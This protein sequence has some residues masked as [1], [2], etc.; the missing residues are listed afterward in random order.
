M[1]VGALFAPTQSAN[2][3]W[4]KSGVKVMLDP[5]H[6]GSDPGAVYNGGG[7]QNQREAFLALWC[8]QK[9]DSWLTAQ[10]CPHKLTRTTD[11]DVSLSARR[12]ASISYDPWVFCSVHLNAATASATGTETWYYWSGRS[13]TLAKKVQNRL[14]SFLG[15]ANRGVKQNGWTVITGASYI[16]AVLTE[17]L[18]I[19][20]AT[21]WGMLKGANENSA[22]FKGWVNGHLCGFYDFMNSESA[23][24]SPDPTTA[25]WAMTT[26]APVPDPTVTVTPSTVDFSCYVGEHPETELKVTGKNLTGNITIACSS[27]RYELVGTG[28]VKADNGTT[29]VTISKGSGTVNATYKVRLALSDA[30]GS[31]EANWMK[32]TVKSSGVTDI[33]IP[34]KCTISNPPLNSFDEKWVLSEKKN[35][36]DSKGYDASQIRNF[37]YNDG[38]LYGVYQH[39]DIIVINA[40]TGEKLG[41]LKRGN[42][43]SGGILDLCDVKVTDDGK[44]VACN[45]AKDDNLRLYTWDNDNAN[46][47]LLKEIAPADFQGASRLG[48]C[49]EVKGIGR[50]HV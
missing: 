44:I 28:V 22:G 15:R 1:L 24:L 8:C 43:V 20:N 11:K 37:C 6:G 49:M 25:G 10:D 23:G 18:F 29:S 36:H 12:S 4:N 42:V 27:S 5:G 39:K 48:D 17:G 34:L 26:V 2:A 16:P 38:K 9:M 3:T 31:W 40:Q 50:A 21:D 46:P 35:N 30:A 14:V 45:L 32:L 47:T 19:S 33:T 7:S 13:N 41:F